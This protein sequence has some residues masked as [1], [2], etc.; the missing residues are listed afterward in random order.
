MFC[1]CPLLLLVVYERKA[2]RRGRLSCGTSMKKCI[3]TDTTLS[4]FVPSVDCS[5]RLCVCGSDISIELAQNND[6]WP[7]RLV[8]CMAL[9]LDNI[10]ISHDF[11]Q[12]HVSSSTDPPTTSSSPPPLPLLH[13]PSLSQITNSHPQELYTTHSSS[14]PPPTSHTKPSYYLYSSH[15]QYSPSE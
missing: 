7:S 10:C 4:N 14:S 9:V 8:Q 11:D 1:G 3:E 6:S 13:T 5:L 12:L 2:L 15:S